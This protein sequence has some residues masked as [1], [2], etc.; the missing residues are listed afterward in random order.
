MVAR[1]VSEVLRHNLGGFTPAERKVARELL[2][3]YPRAGLE[4]V[5]RLAQRAGVSPPSV[6][7]L[8]TK[9]GY[10]GFPDFQEHLRQEVA[11]RSTSALA[12]YPELPSRPA[13]D[14]PADR[15]VL[16][17][18][19]DVLTAGI[20]QTFEAVPPDRLVAAVNL[21]C[22]PARRV[23][24]IGGRFSGYFAG[25]LNAHLQLLRATSTTVPS[26]AMD[27]TALLLD[28][29]RRDVVI[30]YDFRRYQHDTVAFGRAAQSQGAALIV[31]TDP[32]LSPLAV[33]ADVVFP[34]TVTAPSPFDSL[35]P[36]LALTEAL[37]AAVTDCLGDT[38]RRRIERFESLQRDL[39][40]QTES[41]DNA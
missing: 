6:I 40:P 4:T 15:G 35:S 31:F 23:F 38:S 21:I 1:A 12:Q 28:I 33:N 8:V 41:G 13:G 7:R 39:G 25:Y 36:A 2:A 27:R 26:E 16:A 34:C 30:A 19:Q 32:W 29:G 22:D 24:T 5:A 3:D 37:I 10:S 9:L 20:R 11:A 18:A 14:S 17:R